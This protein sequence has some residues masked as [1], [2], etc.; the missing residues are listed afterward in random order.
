[1]L[2]IKNSNYNTLY[3]C[4]INNLKNSNYNIQYTLNIEL[5]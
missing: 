4:K 2:M 1:M 3:T 5:S